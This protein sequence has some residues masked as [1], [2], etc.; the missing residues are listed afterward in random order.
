MQKISRD[1]L[2]LGLIFTA[3]VL[4]VTLI[5]MPAVFDETA[6]IFLTAE[7]ALTLNQ[8]MLIGIALGAGYA[9]ARKQTGADPA[10]L[11][12]NGA[13]AG[14]VTGLALAVF[15]ALAAQVDL[16]GV[17]VNVSPELLNVLSFGEPGVAGLLI[18]LVGGVALGALGALLTRLPARVQSVGV[19]TLFIT[20]LVGLLQSNINSLINPADAL[21]VTLWVGAGYLAAGRYGNSSIGRYIGALADDR[22][23]GMRAP[24]LRGLLAGLLAGLIVALVLLAG[25]SAG[26]EASLLVKGLWVDQSTLAGLIL[27][28]VTGG[29]GGLA[30]M[31]LSVSPATV[32]NMGL[33]FI[34]LLLVLGVVYAERKLSIVGALIVGALIVALQLLGR[35]TS[36][37]ADARH[38]ALAAPQRRRV[39]ILNVIVG[40]LILL[41]VPQISN[42]YIT[43]VLDQVG[44][45]IL[46]GLGLNIV[47]G[48][49][50]LLDLGYVAFFA[51][52]AYATGV[53][54]TPNLVTCPPPGD[55][56]IVMTQANA[57]AGYLEDSY[58][59]LSRESVGVVVDTPAVYAANVIRRT[60][61]VPFDSL[62]AAMAALDAGDIAAVVGQQPELASYLA[63]GSLV[64]SEPFRP[65]RT[66]WEPPR[67]TETQRAAWCGP[68]L[69]FWA[70]W[71]LSGLIAGIAGVLLGIP[72]LR[73]RGD[74]LAI[75]TLGFGEIIRIVTLSDTFADYLGGAQGVTEIPSP[76][77]DLT[78]LSG[79]SDA[80]KQPIAL[81]SASQVY[82]L[83]LFSVL[84]IMFVANR[85][86]HSRLGRS[87]MAMREDED[88]AQAM[89]INLVNA[90][91]L[92]F[93]I[94]ATFSGIGGA[95]FGSWLHSIFPNSFT[96]L[97]SINVLSLI[98]IGG[99]GSIPGVVIGAFALIGLPE[100][101]REFS[102]YRMLAFGAL[103]VV[104]MLLRPEGLLPARPRKLEN[105]QDQEN[106]TGE[107]I[108]PPQTVQ[109]APPVAEAAVEGGN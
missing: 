4:F 62:D 15:T 79:I 41:I 6:M 71:P 36:R 77:I 60:T 66:T 83:I 37:A 11:A 96:L 100:V 14:G 43:S 98:I 65:N 22:A 10:A 51:I 46:M 17:F 2:N 12:L 88:V 91:L 92:A 69:P 53:M 109:A 42:L 8:V 29:I 64:T 7:S 40:V 31:L 26:L 39:G 97:V 49:A 48:Y 61:I 9:A 58:R 18:L 85:L 20:L 54:T 32:H 56:V 19:V 25:G 101:L 105:H 107:A 67:F 78:A 76:V 5:G 35:T 73:M 94:G 108:S 104:M 87:W 95:V 74:Y 80:F 63:A 103:L 30:G 45:Y 23:G 99:M 68:I 3:A 44:L 57:D 34:T 89:G 90:K 24:A 106:G 50:G 75:V 86:S 13:V 81:S 55:N 59:A 70:A 82:Y 38:A 102:D 72:V 28:L 93:S 52:G 1:S 16:R 27:I 21:I 33:A 84:L 47:V